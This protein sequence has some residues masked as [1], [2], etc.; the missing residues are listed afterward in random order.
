MLKGGVIFL[1]RMVC[2]VV[3]CFVRKGWLRMLGKLG[4][5]KGCFDRRDLIN[6][7]V[8]GGRWLG[9]LG[10]LEMMWVCV[11]LLLLLLNGSF[12]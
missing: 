8:F 11:M 12:L 7:I 1:V 5:G 3:V 9:Y 10:F 4:C 2:C 6:V